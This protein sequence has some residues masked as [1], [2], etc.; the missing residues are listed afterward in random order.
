MSC[1]AEIKSERSIWAIHLNISC[2]CRSPKVGIPKTI[3]IFNVK[4]EAASPVSAP[5]L[6]LVAT[7][8]GHS[9]KVPSRLSKSYR[10]HRD[11]EDVTWYLT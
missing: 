1:V 11:L 9:N 5:T 4:F 8:S 6:S 3:Y 7:C 2:L 10:H